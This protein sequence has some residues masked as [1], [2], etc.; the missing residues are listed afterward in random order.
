MFHSL[1]DQAQLS[2][3]EID[4]V[5]SALSR[6]NKG[7][8]SNRWLEAIIADFTE[9]RSTHQMVEMILKG[10]VNIVL[11]RDGYA[12]VLTKKGR[13]ALSQ[14]ARKSGRG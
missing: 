14:L 5:Q 9:A 3:A 13:V 4:R 6:G 7:R 12:F 1:N 2:P 11:E 8:V 10:Q